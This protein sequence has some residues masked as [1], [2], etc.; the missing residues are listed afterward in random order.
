MQTTSLYLIGHEIRF[1]WRRRFQRPRLNN[2]ANRSPVS[3][4]DELQPRHKKFHLE[5]PDIRKRHDVN[6]QSDQIL[7]R[8]VHYKNQT[9]VCTKTATGETMSRM[10]VEGVICSNLPCATSRFDEGHEEM[11]SIVRSL[12]FLS[13]GIYVLDQGVGKVMGNH[14]LNLFSGS[15]L[16]LSFCSRG[17]LAP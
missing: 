13:P 6:R 15:Y 17:K 7:N 9:N 10:I 1:K 4:L 3:F 14:W 5:F 16:A 2:D 8:L 12:P 11:R